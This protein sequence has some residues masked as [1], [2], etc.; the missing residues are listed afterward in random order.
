M[1][2]SGALMDIPQLKYAK[3]IHEKTYWKTSLKKLKV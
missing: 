1:S 3:K 2:K